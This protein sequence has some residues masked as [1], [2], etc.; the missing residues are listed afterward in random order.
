[1][2]IIKF[3]KHY[4]QELADAYKRGYADG[5]DNHETKPE[6]ALAA[7]EIF[8]RR[9]SKDVNR[10]QVDKMIDIVN[11]NYKLVR[12]EPSNGNNSTS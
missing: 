9:G 3:L 6:D 11:Q 4:K 8:A 1:M 7:M 5:I 2:I 12:K 10:E